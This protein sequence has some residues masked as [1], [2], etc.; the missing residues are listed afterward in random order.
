MGIQI[1]CHR[2]YWKEKSERNQAT[3]FQRSF[4]LG[5][6]TETDI[7]DACGKLL[8]CHDMPT[9]NELSLD[10]LLDIM[11]GRNLPLAINIKAD[12][13]AGALKAKFS[14]R[15]HDNWFAFD[16]SVPDMRQY[17]R[18]GISTYTRLSDVEHEP[19]WLEQATGVWVDAF[20]GQWH[21]NQKIRA[22][23]EAGKQVCI[24]SPE[25][26]G[27]P[28]VPMWQQLFELQQALPC[29]Q[30]L[31]ICTDTPEELPF[32]RHSA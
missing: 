16:M 15:G 7:R 2:G 23:L 29:S 8:V 1:I 6:G 17:L 3:A 26:H 24:V 5:L 11:D 22:L 12:G 31:M 4:D 30:H 18:L 13:L 21:D 28:P 9:G 14:E 27:Y 32:W 19:V 20:N 10:E 25:L